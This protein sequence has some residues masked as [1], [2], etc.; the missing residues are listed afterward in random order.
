MNDWCCP[1]RQIHEERRSSVYS[2]LPFA[3]IEPSWLTER[4]FVFVFLT[5]T[6]ARTHAHTHMHARTHTQQNKTTTKNACL[7][8]SAET[9]SGNTEHLTAPVCR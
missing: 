1:F 9:V 3:L 8:V 7:S 2:V 4:F 6:Y 5:H